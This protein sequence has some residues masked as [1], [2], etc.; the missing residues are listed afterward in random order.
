MTHLSLKNV[1]YSVSEFPLLNDVSF[2]FNITPKQ[3]IALIG[4]NG[5]GKSTLLN[6]IAGG[7]VAE[8]GEIIKPSDVR[9]AVLPQEMPEALDITVYDFVAGGLQDLSDLLIQYHHLLEQNDVDDP[10]W[11]NQLSKYQHLIENQNGWL[12]E[13]RI[14][15][16]IQE[17]Q[18]PENKKMKDLSGGWRRRVALARALVQEPDLL[19]LDEPTNHLDLTT[20]QWLEKMLLNYPKAILFITHDRALLRKLAT[21]IVELDRGKLTLFPADY[22][23]YLSRK[24]QALMEEERHNALFDKK[25]A[26]EEKWIRQGI[27]A[28]RT[29]NEGRVRA[30]KAL[31]EQRKLRQ[32]REDKPK[33]ETNDPIQA[34]KMVIQAK[35]VSFEYEP[36][37]PIIEHF[38]FNIQRGD[39]IAIVGGN[40]AGKT[41]LLKLLVGVLQPKSGTIKQSPTNLAA[42]FDQ[43]RDH[44]NKSDTLMANVAEGE[45]FI[46]ING[47][48]KHVI[49]YLGDFL[50]P[51]EKCRASAKNL[52][53]GEQ[54]RLLLARLFAKPANILVLDEPT[55]DLDV[56]SLDVLEDILFNYQ[57]T[58]LIIS[59]D[60]EFIDN[61]ATHCIAFDD[62]GAISINVGGYSDF[63]ARQEKVVNTLKDQNSQNIKTP[64]QQDNVATNSDNLNQ[65]RKRSF[66]EQRELESLPAKLEQLE[67]EIQQMEEAMSSSQFHTRPKEQITNDMSKL[68]KLKDELQKCYKRWEELE[69]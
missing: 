3:R 60:R 65:K 62:N 11:L 39:K 14:N 57:G 29:R 15:R 48:R 53:G 9:I 18:L 34:G 6:I 68:E 61:I 69:N 32:E 12:F 59:H 1:Y 36:H 58:V 27:K 64:K 67:T 55:N 52:S 4:R 2:D 17:L 37:K 20:I 25:L 24:E 43:N 47:K 10:S 35:D 38:T 33:F 49:G 16:T 8:R 50:F 63:L 45:E 22:D 51:P 26:E 21:Q 44:I 42:F 13:E 41:T 23:V 54:N 19:L 5:M 40:G 7:L 31:R 28:R 30:L 66:K 46:E 56:E